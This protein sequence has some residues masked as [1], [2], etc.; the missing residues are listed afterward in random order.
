VN[1]SR[2]NRALCETNIS[3][4]FVSLLVLTIDTHDGTV[5][6]VNAGHMPL[7]L[8]RAGGAFVEIDDSRGLIAGVLSDTAYTT[9][10]LALGDRDRLVLY[11]D[12]VTEAR[13]RERLFYRATGLSACV[14]R[15]GGGDSKS[16]VDVIFDDVRRFVGAAA[17]SDD[18]TVVGITFDREPT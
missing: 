13:N 3:H 4:M 9:A 16:L 17:P 10:T 8:S 7:L 5:T 2:F 11:T 15:T 12:G 6:Y 18:I 14:N 1:V